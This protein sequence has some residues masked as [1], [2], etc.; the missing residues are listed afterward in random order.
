MLLNSSIVILRYVFVKER[1]I[2]VKGLYTAPSIF[3][4]GLLYFFGCLFLNWKLFN[5]I[6]MFLF[7]KIF[8]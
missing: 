2:F 6:A 7:I 3:I 1:V 5:R 8:L 4:P